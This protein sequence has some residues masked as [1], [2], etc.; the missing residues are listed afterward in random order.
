[1]TD[2]TSD[3]NVFVDELY[4]KSML[5]VLPERVIRFRLP[6]LTIL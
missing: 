4:Y 6:D 2:R 3:T 1:M 5:D